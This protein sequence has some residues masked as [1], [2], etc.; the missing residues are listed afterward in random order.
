MCKTTA[1]DNRMRVVIKK[2]PLI[3]FLAGLWSCSTAS[4]YGDID[5]GSNFY[6]AIGEY[7]EICLSTSS[8]SFMKQGQSIINNIDSVGYNDKYILVISITDSL[9]EFW[10]IDKTQK[11][12]KVS[13]DD[14]RSEQLGLVKLSN[15]TKFADSGTFSYFVKKQKIKLFSSVYYRHKAGYN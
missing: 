13:N 12:K 15:V 14:K 9:K 10:L 7:N 1:P 8:Q 5:L 3:V 4:F 11:P 6:Y 2:A